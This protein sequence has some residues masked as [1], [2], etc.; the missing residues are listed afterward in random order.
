MQRA[1][2]YVIY[3]KQYEERHHVWVKISGPVT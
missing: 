1:V 3:H 2:Y